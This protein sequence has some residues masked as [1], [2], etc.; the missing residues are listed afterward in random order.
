[1][2][3][4]SYLVVIQVTKDTI[5]L[6]VQVPCGGGE[7]VPQVPCGGGGLVLCVVVVQEEAK[8]SCYLMEV[9]SLSDHW[10]PPTRAE[11]L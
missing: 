10:I 9:I 2:A 4:G 11:G 8:D 1:M 3:K 7:L 6:L 5:H